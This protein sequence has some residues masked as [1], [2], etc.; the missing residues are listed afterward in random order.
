MPGYVL[1]D[2]QSQTVYNYVAAYSAFYKS[3][4]HYQENYNGNEYMQITQEEN[5]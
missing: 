3:I 5:I 1:Y 2:A 4:A